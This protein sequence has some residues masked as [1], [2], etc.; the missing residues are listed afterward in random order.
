MKEYRVYVWEWAYPQV[1][2]A[3]CVNAPNEFDARDQ[4]IRL[5]TKLSKKK[6]SDFLALAGVT[7]G[8]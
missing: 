1:S 2:L 8:E 6:S 3:V 5:A 4:A 7:Y